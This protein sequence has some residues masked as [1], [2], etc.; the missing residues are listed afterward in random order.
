MNGAPGHIGAGLFRSEHGQV[1]P[2]SNIPPNTI[3]SAVTAAWRRTHPPKC[4]RRQF[5]QQWFCAPASVS[6]CAMRALL[7]G[8]H[9][10]FDASIT[11]AAL[12]A[13]WA[14]LDDV[15]RQ[16]CSDQ[17]E[18]YHLDTPVAQTGIVRIDTPR[19]Q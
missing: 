14:G 9:Q 5:Q 7:A 2:I 1:S 16:P 8:P 18:P 13:E 19:M 12:V 4:K 6:A 3:R 10:H 15:R 11:H 17:S